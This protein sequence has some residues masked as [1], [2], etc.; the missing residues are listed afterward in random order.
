MK[1]KVEQ[2]SEPVNPNG[3]KRYTCPY[4]P[5]QTDR[6]D[7]YNRHE[8]IH[9]DEKPFQCYVCD[10]QFNRADHVKK[11]FMRMHREHNYDI[12][13]IRKATSRQGN[14]QFLNGSKVVMNKT[15]QQRQQ[16]LNQMNPTQQQSQLQVQQQAT[17]PQQ[18]LLHHN[19]LISQVQIK[20]ELGQHATALSLG[21][22]ATIAVQLQQTNQTIAIQQQIPHIAYFNPPQAPG[23][24]G[25]LQ[26]IAGVGG[27][28]KE[29]KRSTRQ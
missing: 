25:P 28:K 4:C 17:H 12:N 13:K 16:Q 9:R 2:K 6:R 23:Q 11:H 19:P 20:Q 10:K 18:Q 24:S 5:Y 15:L 27:T 22:D 8:N 1:T 14:I 29:C 7:L 26:G 21:S 3:E